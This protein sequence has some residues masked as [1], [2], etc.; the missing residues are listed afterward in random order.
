MLTPRR[1]SV[2]GLPSALSYLEWGSRG[3]RAAVLLH[4]ITSNAQA[5]WRVA[6]ALVD[7]GFYVVAFDM[8]GH[9]HSAETGQHRIDDVGSLIA[10]AVRSLKLDVNLVLGHSW[11]GAV[12]VSLAGAQNLPLRRLALMDPALALTRAVGETRVPTF[13]KGLGVPTADAVAGITAA[14]PDW[15]EQDVHWKAEAMEQCRREAVVGFFTQSGDWDLTGRLA[16]LTVPTLLLMAG[17]GATIID[18]AT[19]EAARARLG[20]KGTVVKVPGTTHN[21]Y[22]GSGYAPTLAALLRWLSVE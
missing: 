10:A 20:A 7:Q 19:A 9:G 13:T 12:A 6:P 14:N 8:P 3:R 16:E 17:P 5:W 11:G 22:R 18:S 4:G 1:G 21:M 2:Q 15:H